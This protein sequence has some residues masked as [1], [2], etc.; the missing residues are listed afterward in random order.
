M[1]STYFEPQGSSAGRRLYIQVW[2]SV[3]DTYFSA[4]QTAYIDTSK[5]YRTITLYT[6]VL[7]KMNSRVRNM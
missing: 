7:L 2:Y 3:F 5:T 6:T 1:S 4:Y